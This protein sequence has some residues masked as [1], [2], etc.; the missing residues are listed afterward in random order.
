MGR[1]GVK[2][3]R[4]KAVPRS[5][6]LILYPPTLGQN[7]NEIYASAIE[8][9]NL[10]PVTFT[11]ILTTSSRIKKVIEIIEQVDFVLADVSGRDK[12]VL[13]RAGLAEAFGKP[14][15]IIAQSVEDIPSDLQ[16]V[17]YAVYEVRS[18]SWATDL[19]QDIINIIEEALGVMR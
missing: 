11:K 4:K 7:Y 19:R 17:G 3:S 2:M 9:V 6:C 5:K 1:V 14:V 8:E 16:H 12:D 15:G 18:P 10:E 13:F